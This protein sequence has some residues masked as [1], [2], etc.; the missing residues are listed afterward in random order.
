[1]KNEMLK[2]LDQIKKNEHET[3][4]FL[5]IYIKSFFQ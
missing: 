4:D 5:V 2:R 3:E 1:M